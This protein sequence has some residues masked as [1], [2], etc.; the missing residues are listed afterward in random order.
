ML[1]IRSPRGFKLSDDSTMSATQHS[2][3]R[4]VRTLRRTSRDDSLRAMLPINL[5]VMV[6]VSPTVHTSPAIHQ[7]PPG[8]RLTCWSQV[9]AD[10]RSASLSLLGSSHTAWVLMYGQLLLS[11]KWLIV[12]NQRLITDTASRNH[13]WQ[14]CCWSQRTLSA[15]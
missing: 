10:F 7:C 15:D 4:V 13:S 3:R 1:K 2:R 12:I 6:S 5:S 11:W 9:T 14:F 8:P